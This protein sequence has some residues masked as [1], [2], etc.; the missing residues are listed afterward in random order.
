M[1]ATSAIV[2]DVS[3]TNDTLAVSDL[4]SNTSDIAADKESP[5]TIIHESAD[6]L[7][8][9]DGAPYIHDILTNNT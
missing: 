2:S 4:K 1:F 6:I 5:M 7:K 8:Y 9:E 3:K